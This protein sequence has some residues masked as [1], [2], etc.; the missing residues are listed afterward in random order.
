[1]DE[2]F[3]S[4]LINCMSKYEIADLSFVANDRC[5]VCK[6]SETMSIEMRSKNRRFIYYCCMRCL[7]EAHVEKI[8]LGV[9]ENKITKYVIEN[10]DD[11]KSYNSFDSNVYFLL[12]HSPQ[13]LHLEQ[14]S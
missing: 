5:D 3:A 2:D 7:Q 10:I 12:K 6:E 4:E 14:N 13:H 1:M 11:I 9:V 8:D